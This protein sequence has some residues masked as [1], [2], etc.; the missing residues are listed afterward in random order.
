MSCS[1]KLLFDFRAV[2]IRLR[3]R[4]LYTINSLTH[5]SL[6]KIY[7]FAFHMFNFF[8]YPSLNSHFFAIQQSAQVESTV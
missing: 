7:I 2:V 3:T 1:K 8:F 5:E 4:T 6:F